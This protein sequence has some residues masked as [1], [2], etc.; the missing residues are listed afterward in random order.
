MVRPGRLYRPDRPIVPEL[1]AGAVVVHRATGEVFL[2]HYRDEDRWAFPK[3]HVDPGESLEA[4]ALREVAEE[5]GF[6]SVELG[7]EISEVSYRFY[8]AK[9]EVNVHKT[10]VYFLAR[11]DEREAT[12]EPIFDRGAWVSLP[13][14]LHRVPFETDREVLA[15]A[16]ARLSSSAEGSPFKD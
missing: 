4:T 7:P 2:L 6:R 9:R 3:G 14:A 12:L 10:S 11:T 1:A 13:E 16:E 5:T 15:R 8:S